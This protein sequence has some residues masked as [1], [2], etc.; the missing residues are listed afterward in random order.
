MDPPLEVRLQIRISYLTLVQREP[1]EAEIYQAF[2][3]YVSTAVLDVESL[4]NQIR[5]TVEYKKAAGIFGGEATY[6]TNA[7]SIEL[8]D[9][10]ENKYHGLTI[11]NGKLALITSPKYNELD[12]YFISAKFESDTFGRYTNNVIETFRYAGYHT[13][14]RNKLDVAF[15][16][17]AAPSTAIQTLFMK[18]GVFRTQYRVTEV[19]SGDTLQVKHDVCPLRPYPFCVLQTYTLTCDQTRVVNWYH[20]MVVPEDRFTN[21]RY[22]TN[23]ITV[24][25]QSNN[26]TDIYFFGANGHVKDRGS[27]QLCTNSAYLFGDGAS[28]ANKGYNISKLDPNVGYN[29]CEISLTAGVPYTFHVITCTLSEFDFPTPD[30]ETTRILIHIASKGPAAIISD[31][32]KEWARV[33]LTNIQIEPKDGITA[34]ESEAFSDMQ[35]QIDFSLFNIY[36]CVRDDIRVEMNPLNL[37]NID[38]YGHIYW[39]AELWLLPLLTIIKPYAARALLD[40]RFEQL[41]KAKSMAAAHGY[42]G[43][44]FAY[45]NDTIIGY[46]DVFWDTVSPLYLF[47]SALV[48]INSWNYYR[49]TRDV[50]W[51]QDKGYHILSNVADF[52]ASKA[53]LGED[54]KYH[55]KNVSGMNNVPANDHSMTNYLARTAL[56][57]TLQAH[58][59]LNYDQTT[60]RFRKWVDVFQNLVIPMTANLTVGGPTPVAYQNIIDTDADDLGGSLNFVE[61]LI[62]LHPFYNEKLQNYFQLTSTSVLQAM[63]D[64]A[65]YY[66][67]RIIEGME[68]NSIN[69]L[70]LNAVYGTLSQNADTNNITKWLSTATALEQSAM[71]PWRTLK[72][73]FFNRPYN[74]LAVSSLFILNILTGLAGAK[75]EGAITA[76]RY[77]N[78]DFG[79]A[80]R[81]SSVLPRTWKRLRVTAIHGIDIVDLTNIL[82]YN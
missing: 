41:D 38:F 44:R 68:T 31:N 18:T 63:L 71:T 80:L 70:V 73:S 49:V 32:T 56:E 77:V 72:N 55:I 81:G 17:I 21:V 19:S 16:K 25:N 54:D 8:Y 35:R 39:S 33:W 40:Y 67:S 27:K 23:V 64:N 26:P 1:T 65:L 79:I 15:D 42:L 6:H 5:A 51:L 9:F 28:V 82:F 45:E 43:G 58:F 20:D 76:G 60:V 47:N 57:Y 78:Q 37:S 69:Q 61:P 59:S 29:L 7:S 30:M 12:K 66:E 36:C 46:A 62:I 48:A 75:V 50:S 52:F 11:G 3:D 2:A 13:F 4:E 74:D 24:R 14:S 10:D 22:N 53:E 34:E